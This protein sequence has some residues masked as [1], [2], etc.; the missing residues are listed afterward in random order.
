[1]SDHFH[2]AKVELLCRVIFHQMAL[3]LRTA[4]ELSTANL[5]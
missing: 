5:S 2:T 4:L 3:G 1:M